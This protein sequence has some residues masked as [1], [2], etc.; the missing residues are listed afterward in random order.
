MPDRSTDS[1][2][3]RWDVVLYAGCAVFAAG[4]GAA[5]G[6]ATHRAWAQVAMVGYAAAALLGFGQLLGVRRGAAWAGTVAA[7]GGLAAVTWLATAVVPMLML[8]ARPGDWAQ[9]EVGVVE[10][11]GGRW[12]A[13]G[14]PYQ[15]REAIAALPAGEQIEAYT[16][17]QPA[18]AIFG[19]PRALDP[20]AGWWSDARIWFAA[21][22]VV[23][24]AGAVALLGRA[25]AGNRLRAWQAAAVLPTAAL[26]TAVGG[27]DLP[28]LAL[29]LLGL[30]LAAR[31][32]LGAAGLVVG[33]AAALKLIAWPV[34]VVLAVYAATRGRGGLA[35]FGAGA[36]GLPLLTLLP[37][38]VADPSAVAENT[39]L[40][41]LGTGLVA[42]PAEAPLPGY[43]IATQLPGGT[44][45]GTGL[46]VAAGIAIAVWLV[47]RPPRSAAAAAA[48][49]GFGLLLAMILMP[50][51]RFGYLLYPLALLAWVPALR[52]TADVR[53]ETPVHEPLPHRHERLPAAAG[54]H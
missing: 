35:R 54:R 24:L 1:A 43:L 14:S 40:F 3:L 46:L 53:K 2:A 20:A 4:L 50:A 47:R 7:R 23:V 38:V 9:S 5:T 37:A 41:P 30:A 27:D 17:Y 33:A 29:C 26:A 15:G 48:I 16:P 31:E 10:R 12:L 11:A 32:R 49:S 19:V 13:A 8:I 39:V 51:T 52:P 34:A 6:L 22:T 42:S 18:M 44:V 25:S 45:I 21:V 36:L 28:V